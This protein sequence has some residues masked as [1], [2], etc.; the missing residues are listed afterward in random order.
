MLLHSSARRY[1]EHFQHIEV[2]D[3]SGVYEMGDMLV[4]FATA[5]SRSLKQNKIMEIILM[6]AMSPAP[7]QLHF[8]FHL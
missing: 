1:I 2:Y 4:H 7:G 6:A 8:S 3:L 5:V